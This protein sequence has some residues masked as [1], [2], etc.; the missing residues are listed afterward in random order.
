MLWIVHCALTA[1]A[2]TPPS[3]LRPPVGN[4]H[5]RVAFVRGVAVAGKNELR[6]IGREHG[7][8]VEGRVA[9]DPF[10]GAA[11]NVDGPEVEVAAP[12]VLVVRGEDD[13]FAVGIPVRRKAGAFLG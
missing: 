6:A 4:V 1:R 7:E 8:A 5:V 12:R 2:N 10:E 13:S 11:V 9:R 3:P